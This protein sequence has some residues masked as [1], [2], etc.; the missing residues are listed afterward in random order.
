MNSKIK[1]IILKYNEK[2]ISNLDIYFGTN[3]L[4]GKTNNIIFDKSISNETFNS[5]LD[6]ISTHNYKNTIYK[7]KIYNVNSN[8]LNI[9]SKKHTTKSNLNSLF[10]DNKLYI[11]YS[12]NKLPYN[13]FPSN[14][15]YNI[16]EQHINQ[17]TI[18]N[19]INLLFIN[20]NQLKIS[21][22]LNHNIDHSIEQLEHLFTI[23]I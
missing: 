15:N 16:I 20:N 14:K 18:N 9:N 5:L 1:N 8:Y 4:S 13:S 21:L 19:E 2:N 3:I 6:K 11:Y 12:E 22:I 17:Y 7:Q 23:S 10:D